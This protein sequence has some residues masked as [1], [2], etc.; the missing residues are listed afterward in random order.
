MPNCGE[1]Y[2]EGNYHPED[3]R[4]LEQKTKQRIGKLTSNV[5]EGII[6]RRWDDDE[7]FCRVILKNIGYEAKLP[8][9]KTCEKLFNQYSLTV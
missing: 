3:L 6:H 8:L 2:P 7:A 1:S 9:C 4:T 5:G